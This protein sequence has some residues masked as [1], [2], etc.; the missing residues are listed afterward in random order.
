VA[1][2]GFQFLKDIVP[3]LVAAATKRLGVGGFQRG[4]ECAPEGDAGEEAAV[5]LLAHFPVGAA[6]LRSVS[7]STKLLA[8]GGFTGDCGT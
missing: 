2:G 1:R 4:I 3:H 7:M 6:V 8:T 5:A